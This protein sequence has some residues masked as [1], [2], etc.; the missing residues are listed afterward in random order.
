VRYPHLSAKSTDPSGGRTSGAGTPVKPTAN[1]KWAFERA[2]EFR[3][4]GFAADAEPVDY[5]KWVSTSMRVH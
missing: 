3:L 2:R 1:P 4:E 5:E